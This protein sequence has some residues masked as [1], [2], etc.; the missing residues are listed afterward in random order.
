MRF[1]ERF[2]VQVTGLRPTQQVTVSSTITDGRDSEWSAEATYEAPFAATA[3]N[4][5]DP[6]A[7]RPVDGT[8][9]EPDT[10][11]LIWS[12]ASPGAPYYVPIMIGEETVTITA[13][14]DGDTIGTAEVSRTVL[15]EGHGSSYVTND[16]LIANFFE[17]VPGSPTPAP[18]VIV[19]G[20]SR[21]GLNP[22]T[23]LQAAMLAL[24]GY[25]ALSLAYFG[26]G[27]LSPR[28]ES[29]PLEYF[30]RAIAWLQQQPSVDPN[31]LGV[32]GTSRGGEL[33]LLLGAYYQEFSAVV[34]YVGSGYV[35]PSPYYDLPPTPAWTWQGEP[36]PFYWSYDIGTEELREFEIPVERI[37]GPVLLISGDADALWPSSRLSQVA[38]DRLQRTGHPW[39]DQFLRYPGAGHAIP[40]PYMP[41]GPFITPELGGDVESTATAMANAWPAVTHML[42]A[43]LNRHHGD[44]R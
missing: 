10:M 39:P 1:D 36:I 40:V 33:A 8:F 25:A 34:S 28:L 26:I 16:G 41:V 5:V 23:D 38:W 21:G 42:D 35:H 32:I 14:V 29:I 24:H 15:P 9:D 17:P 11:G 12:A 30:G 3:L 31:R 22:A 20:G 27:P 2:D 13:T 43:R 37:N 7:L 4:I 18:A 6:S 44:T 19:L